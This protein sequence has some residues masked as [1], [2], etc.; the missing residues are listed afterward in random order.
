[1]IFFIVI[2]GFCDGLFITALNVIVIT[3]V[4]QSQVPVAIGW[5]LQITSSVVAG[6]PPVAGMSIYVE[7]FSASIDSLSF[8]KNI[9][10]IYY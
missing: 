5:E 6:G 7:S 3:C 8:L 10:R 2:Y 4:S 1:M 9:R